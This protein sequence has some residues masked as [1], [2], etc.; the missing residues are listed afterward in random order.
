LTHKIV[1][2]A[3]DA[4]LTKDRA[5]TKVQKIVKHTTN[6]VLVGIVDIVYT[7][8]S[9]KTPDWIEG[10]ELGSCLL[11]VDTIKN[12]EDKQSSYKKT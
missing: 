5:L 10:F 1:A 9:K 7:Q 6:D 12:D 2:Q 4:K 11:S 3:R 8:Y